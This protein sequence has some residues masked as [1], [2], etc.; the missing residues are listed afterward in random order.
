M[1]SERRLLD[2][3]VL[4][5]L[6]QLGSSTDTLTQTERIKDDGKPLISKGENFVLGFFSP[7]NSKNRYVGIWYNKVPEQ[8]VVWVANRDNPIPDFTGVLMINRDGNLVVFHGVRRYPFWSTN[9]SNATSNSTAKLLDSGNL[10]LC[11]DS[12]SKFI[13]QSFDHLTDTYLPD[14]KF[15]HNRKTGLKSSLTS[16]K[17]RDDPARGNYS[18]VLDR[19]GL[20]QLF[21]YGGSAP[22]WR[23]GPW[24]GLELSGIPG[25]TRSY[26]YSYN[27]VNNTDEIYIKY[28]MTNSSIFTRFVLSG[29][30]LLQQLM[31]IDRNQRWN[32]FWSAPKDRCDNYGHCGTYGNCNC[33]NDVECQCLQGY[34]PK[35][36]QDWYLRDWSDGCVRRRALEWRTEEGFLKMAH[37]KVPD[38]STAIVDMNLS[39][40]E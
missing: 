11:N 26:L 7:G 23:S 39:L 34:E 9:V 17:S 22:Y 25:M 18:A 21:T 1:A 10:V 29:S 24:N 35:S 31:W 19:R 15:G 6:F 14:M 8:T 3:F 36:P 30:G 16:W 33:D 32:V 28:I 2:A 40:E 5:I 13:W 27:Y 20:P 37:V 4:L 12:C 38:T